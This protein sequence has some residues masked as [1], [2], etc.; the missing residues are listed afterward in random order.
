M[1]TTTFRWLAL[2]A[3]TPA[4]PRALAEEPLKI[5]ALLA[6]TG[7][8]AFLGAPEA[9]TL[10]ML[11]DEAN[12]KGGLRGRKVQLIVKDTGA[13][14]EKAISFATALLALSALDVLV[15]LLTWLEYRRLR[16]SHAAR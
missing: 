15:I 7:P 8:A 4:A 5:G 3:A 2:L 11:V 12:A 13:S 14:P 16:A 9:N 10:Q 6:V 1:R